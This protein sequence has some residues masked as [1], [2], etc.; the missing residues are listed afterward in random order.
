MEPFFVEKLLDWIA[1]LDGSEKLNFWGFSI[2]ALF[3]LSR[4]P[5]YF[6]FLHV[7]ARCWDLITHVFSFGGQE[8]CPTIEEFQALMESRREEKIIS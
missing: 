3:L 8:I 5:L 1:T 6:L 2:N 4:T 7:A